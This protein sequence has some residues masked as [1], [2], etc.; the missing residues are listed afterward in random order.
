MGQEYYTQT[1]QYQ[2]TSVLQNES[3]LVILKDRIQ[4][5]NYRVQDATQIYDAKFEHIASQ[6]QQFKDKIEEDKSFKQE[7]S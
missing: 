2:G 7:I 3:P 1:S 6:L 5:I 4:T